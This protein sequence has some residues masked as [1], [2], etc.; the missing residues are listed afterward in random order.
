MSDK[1]LNNRDLAMFF[2]KHTEKD[3]II[4]AIF[5]HF[6]FDCI[7]RCGINPVKLDSLVREF[8]ESDDCDVNV[9]TSIIDLIKSGQISS[10]NK[11]NELIKQIISCVL[12]HLTEDISF[13]TIAEEL[14][15]S[16]YYMCH[17]FKNKYSISIN[18]FRTQKRL[19]IAMRKLIEST[20]KITD[21]AVSCGFNNSSYFTEI[22]T[23]TVGV[24]PTM[25]RSQ[26]QG[27]YLHSFYD[28]H[29]ILLATKLHYVSCI[30]EN[31]KELGVDFETISVHEP[32]NKFGFL[33]E[34]AIIEYNGVLYASWYNCPKLELKGY[35]P[36]CGKRS[37]DGGKTWTDLEVICKDESEKILYCPPA[38][39]VCDDKLYMFV[40]Q[41]VAPDHIHSLDLYVLN[42]TTNKFEFVWSR[43]IPF[44]LNTNVISLPNGKLMLPGRIGELDGFPIT[45]AVLISD[46]GKIDAEWRLVKIAENG[47]LPDGKKLIHPEISVMCVE[48]VLYMFN[49]NDQRRVPLV[50]LSKD[51]GETWSN[52]HSHNIPYVSSKMYAGNLSDGRNYLVANIDE[53]DRSKLVV[54]FTNKCSKLFNKRVML[55]DKNTTNL[56]NSIACHYPCAF[57]SNGK[58][59]IIA[60]LGYESLTRGAILFI[61][62]LDKI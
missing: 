4:A 48:D 46:N 16:Y 34:A 60:T 47:D 18:T 45:P 56:K 24:S 52:A 8:N 36:I 35:T 9:I 15:V 13:E 11:E 33:H 42:N 20:E 29:D 10:S 31:I 40:N 6:R 25:F 2:I 32:D 27:L 12:E 28:F 53:F 49:R 30:D 59:Y 43:P 1:T 7:E 22:F 3:N 44:K 51:F 5:D 57:E 23:K 26:N 41:M 61:L 54:Y 39:G 50:Y 17:I 62:D 58:L 55:Y 37:Y 14:N 19:E 21:I 38:Y